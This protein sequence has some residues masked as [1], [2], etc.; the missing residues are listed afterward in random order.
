M[1]KCWEVSGSHWNNFIFKAL[2]FQ[3]WK[4]KGIHMDIHL[5]GTKLNYGAQSSTKV[6]KQVIYVL[7]ISSAFA[8]LQLFSSSSQQHC[9]LLCQTSTLTHFQLWHLIRS[10]KEISKE[11]FWRDVCELKWNWKEGWVFEMILGERTVFPWDACHLL[12][13]PSLMKRNHKAFIKSS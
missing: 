7:K 6:T 9:R 12:A 1:G 11:V 5:S 13:R 8:H 10:N 4:H 3:R 2:H